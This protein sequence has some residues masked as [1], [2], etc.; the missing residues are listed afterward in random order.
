MT[1][2]AR[3][4]L[5]PLLLSLLCVPMVHA[6]DEDRAA[7]IRKA[8]RVDTYEDVKYFD[9]QNN[10]ITS[11]QFGERVRAGAH[12]SMQKKKGWFGGTTVSMVLA[13]KAPPTLKANYKIKAGEA[14]PEFSHASMT[15]QTI[16]NKAV[17][18]RYTLVSFYFAECA[19][20]IDEVP[21]L[22]ALAQERRDMNLIGITFDSVKETR[23]FVDEHKLAW[24]LLPDAK[25]TIRAA[26]VNYFPSLA[27]LDPQGK[28]IAIEP[29]GAIKKSDKTIAAWVARLAPELKN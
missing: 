13:T 2:S 16:D 18:G 4:R 7:T 12:V 6:Q 22:N 19:P 11:E 20:C 24:T 17:A 27:L 8:M 15:S 26:G 1:F 3:T 10:R 5:L 21:E 28:V 9:E 29:G 14:F 25:S 23:K